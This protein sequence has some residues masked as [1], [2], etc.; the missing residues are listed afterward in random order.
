MLKKILCGAI[1]GTLMIGT[2]TG[3]GGND[4]G[5]EKKETTTTTEAEVSN[6]DVA[7]QT[8]VDTL[9]AEGEFSETLAPVDNS[10][11]LSRLYVL[12]SAKIEEAL[13]YTSSGAT[14]EEI[15]VIKV[16]DASY[17]ETVKAAFDTR[18]A[19]QKEAFKD[20]VPEEVPKLE[21][22]VIYT[23]GNY[24]ILCVSGDSGKIDSAIANIFK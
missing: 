19:D 5:A 3:C 22:A 21:D 15:V 6:V 11:A 20:Y 13:F 24:A 9:Q 18:I 2:L 4:S 10:M 7:A 17:M 8:I 16:N 23:N 14:A 1:L 12:D